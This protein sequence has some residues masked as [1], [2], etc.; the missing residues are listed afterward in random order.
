MEE[1]SV[2]VCY[3]GRR[4]VVKVATPFLDSFQT[5]ALQ[6]FSDVLPA[7]LTTDEDKRPGLVFQMQGGLF[8]DIEKAQVIPDRSVVRMIVEPQPE[9]A[10]TN[11]SDSVPPVKEIDISRH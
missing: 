8:I 10:P 7:N 3:D 2:L 5:S 11:S 6:A 9:V 1:C 4:R